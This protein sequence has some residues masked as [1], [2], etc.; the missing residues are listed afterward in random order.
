MNGQ[1]NDQSGVVLFDNQ[2]IN[3]SWDVVEIV[4]FVEMKE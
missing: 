4:C 1:L 2:L 3:E